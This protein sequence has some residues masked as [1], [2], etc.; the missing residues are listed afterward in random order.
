MLEKL[1]VI[2][3]SIIIYN[4]TINYR[5]GPYD[6]MCSHTPEF[7]ENQGLED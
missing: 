6:F 3:M 1:A 2:Y 5:L 7:T 4:V